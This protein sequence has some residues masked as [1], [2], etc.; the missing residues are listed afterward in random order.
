MCSLLARIL[1]AILSIGAV[2]LV[3]SHI[4]LVAVVSTPPLVSSSTRILLMTDVFDRL[5]LCV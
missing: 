1:T 4:D 2:I 5:S 3:L